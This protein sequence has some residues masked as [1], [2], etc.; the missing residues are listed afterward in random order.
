[1]N[2]TS[3]LI[4]GIMGLLIGFNVQKIAQQIIKYK[5]KAKGINV[6]LYSKPMR[7]VITVMNGIM[8]GLAGNNIDNTIIGLM[9]ALQ[10]TI[11]IIIAFID[12]DIRIIPNELVLTMI[13]VGIIFQITYFGFNGLIVASISMIVMMIAFTSVAGFVGFGK[14]GA[15]DV[16][17]A[18]AIA[19]ALGY[20]LVSLAVITMAVVL[21][22]YITVGY[23]L[24]KVYLTTMLPLAPFL[25]SG[26]TAA[27]VSIIV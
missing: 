10:L 25:I 1:M 16:K 17:L 8:W 15:G 4:F 5:K 12:L 24:K 27:L 2:I 21:L 7:G 22:I 19:L 6:I 26:Y 3:L 23:A 18:G 9:I 13:I 20:P 11:G 14:V